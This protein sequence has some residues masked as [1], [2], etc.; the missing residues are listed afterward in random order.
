MQ[1]DAAV[2]GGKI[3]AEIADLNRLVAAFDALA[4]GGASF[5]GQ[6]SIYDGT[7]GNTTFSFP[8]L[9]GSESAGLFAAAKAVFQARVDALTQQLAE[10]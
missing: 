4:A 1:Y 2:M 9:T 5:S 3:A 7:N 10:L 8:A 6:A